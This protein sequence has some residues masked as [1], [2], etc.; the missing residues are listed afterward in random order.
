MSQAMKH[1]KGIIFDL[2][3]TLYDS[4]RL[5]LFLILGDPLNIFKLRAERIARKELAGHVFASSKELYEHIFERI[6]SLTSS[7]VSSVAK[8][9]NNRYMPLMERVLQR[10]YKKRTGIE[11]LFNS[12][13]SAGIKVAVFSDYGNVDSR[14]KALG[15]DPSIVDG[16]YAAPDFGAL[17]PARFSFESVCASLG[18][19]PVDVLMVGDREDTDGV[20]AHSCKMSFLH[21]VK[22]KNNASKYS[23]ENQTMHLIWEEL[24][25]FLLK[26]IL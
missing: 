24:S 21:L 16:I 4:S 25:T 9:Y 2:D 23:D 5:P 10:H 13:R 19:N 17:K 26:S 7:P 3:G 6:S 11:F 12:L 1:Y 18:L 15:I 14:L 22:D 20:G 8:W